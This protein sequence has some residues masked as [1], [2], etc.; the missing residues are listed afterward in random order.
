MKCSSK[1]ILTKLHPRI[2]LSWKGPWCYFVLLVICLFLLKVKWA[3]TVTC[4]PGQRTMDTIQQTQLNESKTKAASGGRQQKVWWLP[5]EIKQ[6]RAFTQLLVAVWLWASS[7]HPRCSFLICET[8]MI[9]L[10]Y[11][12]LGKINRN[13]VKV[14]ALCRAHRQCLVIIRY[15][16]HY[17]YK[18]RNSYYPWKNIHQDERCDSWHWFSGKLTDGSSSASYL[19]YLRVSR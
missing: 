3:C 4:P 10:F 1:W 2:L 11:F 18:S 5:Q 14:L 7:L 9:N 17:F 12:L 19:F 8:R 13:Q 6:K 15:Y 16:Y